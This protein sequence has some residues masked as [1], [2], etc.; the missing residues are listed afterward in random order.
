MRY[1][2]LSKQIMFSGVIKPGSVGED[3]KIK[4]MDLAEQ[5]AKMPDIASEDDE[6]DDEEDLKL[7]SNGFYPRKKPA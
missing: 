7:D 5:L 1:F 2:Q 4:E 6:E 3:G